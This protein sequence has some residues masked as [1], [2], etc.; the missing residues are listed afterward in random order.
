MNG[1]R[2]SITRSLRLGA[3]K[4]SVGPAGLCRWPLLAATMLAALPLPAKEFM[5]PMERSQWYI[6]S[7]I[8]ECTIVHDIPLY[9]K[10][11]FYHEAGEPL[12]FF[13]STVRNPMQPGQAALV[14]EASDW[15][16]GAEVQDLGYVAVS[17]GTKPIQVEAARSMSMMHG[18]LEGMAPAFTRKS[19][20]KEDESIRVR[21]NSINFNSVYNAYLDCVAALLPVNFRQVERTRV[22]FEV[23]KAELTRA[24]REALDRVILYVLA[25]SS[26]GAIYVDGH[27][28]ASGRRIYN[29]RLS[30]L[31]AE[32]VTEYLDPLS[33]RALSGGG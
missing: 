25:D 24:D 2:G 26:V 23:D 12:Q 10:A 6:S 5:A 21:L 4:F 15:R 9:G 16:P 33:R 31:R 7:S 27:T 19:V 8:F 32:A 28:D 29:R 1:A 11:S 13:T 3:R 30:K 14:I 22:H 18:L 17:E 20:Y